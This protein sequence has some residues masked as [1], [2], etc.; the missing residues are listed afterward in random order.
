MKQLYKKIKHLIISKYY[1][2]LKKQVIEEF[3]TYTG[4]DLIEEL[5]KVESKEKIRLILFKLLFPFDYYEID[6]R[7]RWE[8]YGKMAKWQGI[9]DLF[10][11]RYSR[12]YEAYFLATGDE[13]EQLKG[14]ILD[15]K[16]IIDSCEIATDVLQNWDKYKEQ[17]KNNI[18]KLSKYLTK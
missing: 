9:I 7:R 18:N 17:K 4:N 5:L 6:E 13:K 3:E 8:V 2:S 12:S 15:N 1:N 10:K 11:S 16:N 14:R